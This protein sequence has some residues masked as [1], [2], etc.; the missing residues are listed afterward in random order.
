MLPNSKRDACHKTCRESQVDLRD[1]LS[2]HMGARRRLLSDTRG[3]ECIDE[4]IAHLQER[5]TI[6]A[7]MPVRTAL[8]LSWK[9]SWLPTSGLQ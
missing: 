1:A 9:N 6:T 4:L 7:P 3:S 2:P 8:L 5:G